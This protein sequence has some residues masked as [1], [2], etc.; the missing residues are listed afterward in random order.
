MDDSGTVTLYNSQ[1]EVTLIRGVCA[2]NADGNNYVLDRS[3]V[4]LDNTFW[5]SVS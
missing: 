2:A 1:S 5:G 3:H 4:N